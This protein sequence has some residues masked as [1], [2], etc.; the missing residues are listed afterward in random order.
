MPFTRAGAEARVGK[1]VRVRD[2]AYYEEGLEQGMRGK[3]VDISFPPTIELGIGK[4]G[5]RGGTR[6]EGW[7]VAVEFYR[8]RGPSAIFCVDKEEYDR[9]L[10]EI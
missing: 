2:D 9:L 5:I 3:V 8:S 7:M 1:W 4:H 6:R 10:E